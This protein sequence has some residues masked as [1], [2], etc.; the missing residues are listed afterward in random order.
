MPLTDADGSARRISFFSCCPG[1]DSNLK[2]RFGTVLTRYVVIEH[3][4]ETQN[5]ARRL[6]KCLTECVMCEGG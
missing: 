1:H 3:F 4:S 5:M 6:I 2:V